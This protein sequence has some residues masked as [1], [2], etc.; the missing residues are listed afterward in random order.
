[1]SVLFGTVPDADLMNIH[2]SVKDLAKNNERII[3]NLEHSMT[4][5]NLSRIQISKNRRVIVE[6]IISVQKLD[7]KIR[8]VK[9]IFQQRFVKLEHF[10]NT[11]YNLN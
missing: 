7:G 3:H 5:L 6:L 2:N 1:M 8:F 10:I 4:I 11:V 9:E